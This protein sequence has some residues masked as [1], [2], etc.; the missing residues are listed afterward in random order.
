MF[1]ERRERKGGR[2]KD[3]KGR[4]LG[5]KKKSFLSSKAIIKIQIFF[6]PQD[7]ALSFISNRK[8][9]EILKSFA[10]NFVHFETQNPP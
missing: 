7:A 8:K 10:F 1:K 3:R 2:E 4:N 9:I 5:G 6:S